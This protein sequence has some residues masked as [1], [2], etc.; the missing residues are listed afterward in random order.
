MEG[1][2]ARAKSNE[3][4]G[5]RARN[6][7]RKARSHLKLEMKLV[8]EQLVHVPARPCPSG[9][10][11]GKRAR[12]G[13]LLWSVPPLHTHTHI[14]AHLLLGMSHARA[15]A[16]L[17]SRRVRLYFEPVR[18]GL[19]IVLNVLPG[20]GNT[21]PALCERARCALGTISKGLHGGGV[22]AFARRSAP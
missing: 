20:E 12:G 16:S 9:P 14:H 4:R 21:E 18:V 19:L 22:C 1:G 2:P 11:Q 3:R 17:E 7:R 15:R 10:A 5:A 6:A 8:L 13:T